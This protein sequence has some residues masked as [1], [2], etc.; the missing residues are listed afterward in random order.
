MWDKDHG[1]Q[2]PGS[3]LQTLRVTWAQGMTLWVTWS[4]AMTFDLR[5]EGHLGSGCSHLCS[6]SAKE[7]WEGRWPLWGPGGGN[8]EVG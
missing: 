6:S 4:Q 3:S 2:R 5:P 7:P 1:Q 8:T